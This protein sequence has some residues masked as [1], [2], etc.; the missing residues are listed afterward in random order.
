[1]HRPYGVFR[2]E[3]RGKPPLFCIIAGVISKY[4]AYLPALFVNLTKLEKNTT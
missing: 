3:E 1:L 4:P 2:R